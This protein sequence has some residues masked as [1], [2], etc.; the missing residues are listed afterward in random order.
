[1]SESR[2][3]GSA[4]SEVV[5]RAATVEDWWRY[6]DIRLEALSS[7]PSA[8]GSTYSGEIDR[9]EE[10]W[11]ERTGNPRAL[12]ALAGDAVVG[13][14]VGYDDPD[15]PAGS[16]AL[17]SM[18][19]TP[20]HRGTG[21][22]TRLID[23]I[24]ADARDDD[25]RELVLWVTD[26]N[27][28]ARKRYEHSGFV[29]TGHSQPLPRDP[30]LT[31]HRMTLDLSGAEPRAGTGAPETGVL[32]VG[33]DVGGTT[34]KAAL[35]DSAAPSVLLARAV[36]ASP[37]PGPDAGAAVL[38]TAVALVEDL[39]RQA[40]GLDLPAPAAVGIAV[41]GVID[42]PAGVA[43]FASAFGWSDEPV[44]D[45][46]SSRTG[47][48][49]AFGH[50]VR[51]AGLAEW[52]IGAGRGSENVLLVALGTGIGA[53]VVV[54]GRLLTA[55]GYAGQLG[56]IV[57][58]PEGP[59]CG[60]GQRGCVGMLASARAIHHR[61]AAASG[62][63][64]GDVDGAREV[65]ALVAA[66]D[67]VAVGVWADAIGDLVVMLVA[68]ST[69]LGP[70]RLVLAGGP[71]D[72]GELLAGPVRERLAAALT[73]QRRPEVVVAQLGSDAGVLGSALA[74]AELSAGPV[75]ASRTPAAGAGTGA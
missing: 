65:A 43:V 2:R 72:A 8:F 36:A 63:A 35:V 38:A 3:D 9:S 53:A 37:E 11:R 26:G 7:A 27:D 45:E 62:R 64:V 33:I 70:E 46:L 51:S 16:R 55:G 40:A 54:D 19:V 10:L 67:P 74:A 39:R 32:T 1:V 18:F 61:Y 69:L 17:V 23:A 21:L 60:C 30:T 20:A 59:I 28:A 71:S 48:P 22:S 42:E 12:L 14:A 73:Y 41:P 57:V 15:E 25:V 4:A 50:D 44:R 5:I 56:H 13:I 58:R 47:L 66:G 34:V 52:R 68:A 75:G 6:R 49:V 31:E 24:A 29:A